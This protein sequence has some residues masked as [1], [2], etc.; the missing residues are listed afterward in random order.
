MDENNSPWKKRWGWSKPSHS[1]PHLV[2]ETSRRAANRD[3]WTF[4]FR[5]THWIIRLWNAD[6]IAG[7][8][9]PAA[10]LQSHTGPVNSV[11]ILQDGHRI[12]SGSYD[13]T[14]WVWDMGTG[15]A[16][17]APLQ[18]H[19]GSVQSVAISSDGHYIVSGS[20]DASIQVWD[21][22]TGEVLG[23]PLQGHTGTVHSIAI[24]LDGTRVVS[25]SFNDTIRMWDMGTREAF[26]SPIK[27]HSI[28]DNLGVECGAGKALGAPLEEHSNW[29]WSVAVSPDTRCVVSDSSDT[30]VR[31]WDIGTGKALGAPL[32]G[33]TG[34]VLAVA[35]SRNGHHIVSGSD[36]MTISGVGYEDWRGSGRPFL[37][38]HWNCL[39]VR[40]WDIEYLSQHHSFTAPAICFSPNPTYAIH[41]TPSFLQDSSTPVSVTANED[42]WVVGPDEQLLLWIPPNFHPLIYVPGNTY[43]ISHTV[44]LGTSVENRRLPYLRDTCSFA[45]HTAYGHQLEGQDTLS[46][47]IDDEE[48]IETSGVC[49]VRYSSSGER[50]AIVTEKNICIYNPGTMECIKTLKGHS[51]G[52]FTLTWTLQGTYLLSGG[53]RRDA[54]IRVWD[55]STWIEICDALRGHTDQIN[56]ISVNESTTIITSAS[57]DSSVRLWPFPIQSNILKVSAG[58][59][60]VTFSVDGKYIF[61]GGDDRM[62]S[63]W[64]LPSTGLVS[65]NIQ[66]EIVILTMSAAARTACTTGNLSTAVEICTRDITAN[67]SNYVCYGNRSIILAH[68]C[69]WDAALEDANQSI[70]IQISAAGYMSKG[71]ALCGKGRIREAC[72]AFDLALKLATGDSATHHLL[73]LIKAIPIFNA[74]SQEDAI[75]CVKDIANVSRDADLLACNVV[76]FYAQ[77]G[78]TALNGNILDEAI[79]YI[80]AAIR[81]GNSCSIQ[82]MDFSTYAEFVVIFGWDLQIEALECYRTLMAACDEAQKADLLAWFAGVKGV[83][84]KPRS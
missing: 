70:S 65:S 37:R 56:A 67:S 79:E 3:V 61:S 34:P 32:Q 2:E 55:A 47:G 63:Q 12:V 81:I 19:T 74:N 16:F 62:I 40:V 45:R 27:N 48:S 17:G 43:A 6:T 15:Q 10:S 30:T 78:L 52:T 29:V 76:Q 49:C 77:M 83:C 53:G 24:S 33:H 23:A 38:A 57:S 73:Y 64:L 44:H 8:A 28:W 5:T 35:I 11:A 46:V 80:T 59:F 41:P 84:C 42:G 75:M 18:G 31:V 60:C 13:K 22:G 72:S 36:D 21:I 68:Q 9:S 25:G 14:V 50:L 39:T 51:G 1:D 66:V 71:I 54:T 4:V 58:A 69:Q 82:T 7:K 26:G 20:D